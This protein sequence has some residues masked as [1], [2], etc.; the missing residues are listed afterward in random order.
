MIG[1]GLINSVLV[2]CRAHLIRILLPV[3]RILLYYIIHTPFVRVP[4]RWLLVLLVRSERH[5]HLLL[6]VSVCRGV[7]L[8]LDRREPDSGLGAASI[9]LLV[10][11]CV[12]MPIIRLLCDIRLRALVP[13]DVADTAAVLSHIE[14][15][16]VLMILH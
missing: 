2:G 7:H 5:V 14:G 6:E 3:S 4:W 10:S 8:L 9:R 15:I 13:V 12:A 16:R 1:H 11:R